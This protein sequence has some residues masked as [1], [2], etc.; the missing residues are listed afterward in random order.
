LIGYYG[1]YLVNLASLRKK[2]M[3]WAMEAFYK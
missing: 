3:T 2:L 1:D